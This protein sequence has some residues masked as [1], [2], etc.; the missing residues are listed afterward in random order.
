VVGDPM[1]EGRHISRLA[2]LGE[3][4]SQGN[5]VWELAGIFQL[6]DEAIE[7]HR[8]TPPREGWSRFVGMCEVGVVVSPDASVP[9]PDWEWLA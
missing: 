9:I 1:I 8:A 2:V 7:A 4:P 6:R 3:S 5:K